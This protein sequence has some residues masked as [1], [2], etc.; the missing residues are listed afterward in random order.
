MTCILSFFLVWCFSI[1][2]FFLHPPLFKICC[3]ILE[4]LIY[5]YWHNS[6]ASNLSCIILSSLALHYTLTVYRSHFLIKSPVI[7]SFPNFV[8]IWA[9]LN[10]FYTSLTITFH[11]LH[12]YLSHHPYIF[13]NPLSIFHLCTFPSLYLYSVIF[14]SLSFFVPISIHASFP[15]LFQH[16]FISCPSPLAR[17][18]SHPP[19]S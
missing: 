11:L 4:F 19:R 3:I 16:P 1:C 18:P 6:Q 8:S 9:L 17:S 13:R 12:S 10:S 14:S 2:Y 5:F 15:H 7:Y